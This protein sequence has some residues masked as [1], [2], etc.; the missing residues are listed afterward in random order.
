MP[1][2]APTTEERATRGLVHAYLTKAY[3]RAAALLEAQALLND[4][5]AGADDM[6]VPA[7]KDV[8]KVFGNGANL[9]DVVAKRLAGK[10][11]AASRVVS[12]KPSPKAPA[13]KP[14][15]KPVAMDSDSD[16]DD[17]PAKKPVM[18]KKSPAA[19]PAAKKPV[20]SDSDSDDVPVK[21]KVASRKASPK[22]APTKPAAAATSRFMVHDDSDDDVAIPVKK[23]MSLPPVRPV[24]AD[25]DDSD[26]DMKVKSANAGG[27][28]KRAPAERK[29]PGERFCRINVDAVAFQ[30]E[31]LKDNTCRGDV[32]SFLQNQKMLAVRGKEFNKHKQKNKAK[33]YAAGVDQGV[34]SYKFDSDEE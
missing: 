10:K 30:N 19:K 16:S 5:D 26:S 1:A 22:A 8:A 23:R 28:G 24:A 21:P 31:K 34:H 4:F 25:A 3:P 33:L 17:L 29:A 15:K 13:A 6:D 11:K 7:A 32:S 2:K 18:A 9:R 20:A 27:A 12:A 14:A